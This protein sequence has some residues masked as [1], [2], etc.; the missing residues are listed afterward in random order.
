MSSKYK[1]YNG[2]RPYFITFAT[3]QWIDVFTR[4]IYKEIIVEN[5]VYCINNKGLILHAFVI[6]SNHI[7]IIA[8]AIKGYSLSDILR[9]F[10]KYTSKK[11]VNEIQ[12]NVQESRKSWMNWIFASAGK[13]N[14][15]NKDF[16]FWQQDNHPI[17]LLTNE[18]MDQKIEYIHLNPVQQGIVRE[19]S[20]YIYSSASNYET[21]KGII[22]IMRID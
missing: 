10:K 9:D 13:N 19:A 17:E 22:D 20:H 5:L 12:D 15:N 7:H 18:M 4:H 16:Q 6:M 1:I 11:I 21:G 8:S 14:T 2:Q 3:V